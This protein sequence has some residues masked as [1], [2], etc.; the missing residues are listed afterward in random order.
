MS[1]SFL[2]LS[3]PWCT[4]SLFLK[5][6]SEFNFRGDNRRIKQI[7]RMKRIKNTCLTRHQRNGIYTGQFLFT[8]QPKFG[9]RCKTLF[10]L[11]ILLM[12]HAFQVTYELCYMSFIL[13]FMFCNTYFVLSIYK[14]TRFLFYM[15]IMIW[16]I[17]WFDIYIYIYIINVPMPYP[18][19]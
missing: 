9:L 8:S 17:L 19:P 10:S 16:F 14:L 6:Y 2:F 1:P 3:V 11:Y 5:N 12:F 15:R 4:G 18:Y 7:Y 13:S